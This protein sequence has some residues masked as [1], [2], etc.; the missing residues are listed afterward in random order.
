VDEAEEDL[1]RAQDASNVRTLSPGSGTSNPI[2]SP[3]PVAESVDSKLEK[4]YEGLDR[5]FQSVRDQPA[6]ADEN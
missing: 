4:H 3:S 1:E 6:V 2:A 5:W